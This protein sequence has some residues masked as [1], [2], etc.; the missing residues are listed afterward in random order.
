MAYLE[1]KERTTSFPFL[2]NSLLAVNLSATRVID[3][4][5]R[6]LTKADCEKLKQA[7]LRPQA[8]KAEELLSQSWDLLQKQTWHSTP[9][10]Y[11]LMGRLMVRVGLHLCKKETKGGRDTTQ[12]EN[13][14]EIASE[15]STEM[16]QVGSGKPP[17]TRMRDTNEEAP[18]EPKSL[19]AC[20]FF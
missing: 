4:I 1:F 14:G 6:C 11:N 2:R 7:S 13:L 10:A 9:E 3:G 19:Q 20:S 5:G 12:Y 16:V 18:V 15:F 17:T 8:L